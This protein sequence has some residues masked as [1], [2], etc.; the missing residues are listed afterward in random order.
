MR[1]ILLIGLTTIH[2]SLTAADVHND[3]ERPVALINPCYSK[4]CEKLK[5]RCYDPSDHRIYIPPTLKKTDIVCCDHC[6][7]NGCASKLCYAPSSE[8][9]NSE[10]QTLKPQGNTTPKPKGKG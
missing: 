3:G 4:E 8:Q 6:S 5:G 9:D 10:T 1:F 7:V 2:L